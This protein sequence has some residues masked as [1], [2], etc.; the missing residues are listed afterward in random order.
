MTT[1]VASAAPACFAA[2][3]LAAACMLSPGTF[4]ADLSTVSLPGERLPLVKVAEDKIP[5]PAPLTGALAPNQDL[6]AATPAFDQILGCSEYE[7]V[8]VRESVESVVIGDLKMFDRARRSRGNGAFSI[9]L[10]RF[11]L[12]AWRLRQQQ[13][14]FFFLQPL[15]SVFSFLFLFP[16][17][18]C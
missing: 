5:Q 7:A 2:A 17:S 16:S 14:R 18:R 13:W 8:F 11:R 3:L 12:L 10:L 1:R 4:A 15:L 9:A 6:Q